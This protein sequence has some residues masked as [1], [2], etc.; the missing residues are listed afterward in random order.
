MIEAIK[1]SM[2]QKGHIKA[3]TL[4]DTMSYSKSHIKDKPHNTSGLSVSINANRSVNANNRKHSSSNGSSNNGYDNESKND[5]NELLLDSEVSQSANVDSIE[6]L[7]EQ[8]LKVIARVESKLTGKDFGASTVLTVTDQVEQLIRQ[9]TSHM[10]L[11][12]AYMGW[13][14][15]W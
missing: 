2:L 11:S 3:P 5:D 9:A 14:P 13:C 8:A 1:Q 6:V 10:N 12:Q 4:E 7:N 15:F